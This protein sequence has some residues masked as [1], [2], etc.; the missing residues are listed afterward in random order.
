MKKIT[1]YRCLSSLMLWNWVCIENTSFSLWVRNGYNE[2]ENFVTLAWK[3]LPRI[4]AL[5]D[6]AHS[7]AMKK[8]KCCE[9]GSWCMKNIYIF[10]GAFSTVW[11]WGESAAIFCCQL[12]AWVPDT[13]CNFYLVKNRKISNNSATT[14]AREKISTD[15]EFL[16][17]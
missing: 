8:I 17:F 3:G 10:C 5:A 16:K 11:E 13:F 12:A 2:L 7:Q 9:K 1:I 6:W 4:N 14:K 15:L